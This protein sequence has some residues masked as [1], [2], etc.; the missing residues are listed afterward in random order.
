M[1]VRVRESRKKG[2][3]REKEIRIPAGK[4]RVYLNNS[5]IENNILSITNKNM[6]L[7]GNIQLVRNE[8]QQLFLG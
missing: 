4:I 8:N 7:K 2:E 6:V 5:F 1:K 3:D